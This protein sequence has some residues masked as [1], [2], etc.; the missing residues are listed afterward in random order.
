LTARM[1]IT[2]YY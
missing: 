2:Y 1:Q